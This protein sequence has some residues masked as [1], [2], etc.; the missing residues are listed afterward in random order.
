MH[1]Y[2]ETLLYRIKEDP[3]EHLGRRSVSEIESYF[4]GYGV[5][6][7]FWGLP[8]VP[9]RLRREQFL[10]WQESKVHLC[11][12]SLQS[13]CLLQTEDERA[14]FDLFFM[15]YDAALE[16]CR[17]SLNESP[18][19]SSLYNLNELKKSKTLV[20]F[21]SEPLIREKPAMYFGNHRWIQGFWAMCSGFLWAERDMGIENSS[22]A[23]TFESFQAWLN[24]RYPIGKE[25]TWDR[26]FDFLA[27]NY[28]KGALN[29]FYEDFEMFL[30]GEAPDT[31]SKWIQECVENAL[32]RVGNETVKNQ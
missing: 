32:K 27:L 8:E 5:A 16:E 3:L 15:L 31:P 29:Q 25:T 26:L 21:V 10:G 22:D 12:Q 23:K 2:Y 4:I 9:R 30:N 6:R 1:P 13:F 14:A 11:N 18:C 19:I 24:E 28:Q 7:S 17:D 20:Q